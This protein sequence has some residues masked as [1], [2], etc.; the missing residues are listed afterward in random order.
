M[1]QLISR[2]SRSG[3]GL[4]TEVIA[5]QKD[6]VLWYMP[7]LF[8]LKVLTDTTTISKCEFFANAVLLVLSTSSLVLSVLP[9]AL[10]K[11]NKELT[12]PKYFTYLTTSEAE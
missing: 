8:T 12:F 9:A 2:I 4:Y 7:V 6:F 5:S 11:A 1:L 3:F 10:L